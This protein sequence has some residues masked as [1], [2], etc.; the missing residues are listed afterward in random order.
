MGK[1]WRTAWTAMACAALVAAPAATASEGAERMI[2]EVN[3]LRAWHGLPPLAFSKSL[4]RSSERY[5]AWQLKADWFGHAERIRTG[6]SWAALG[7][8]LA[9]HSGHRPRVSATLRRWARSP[10][11][12][13]LLLSPLFSEAGA[14]VS[15]GRFGRG[16]ATVWV[17]QLGSR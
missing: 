15:K 14:G 13:A 5:A 16:R 10:A 2:G 6:G 9:I 17:L 12:A 11:H 1:G 4:A 3:E 7:E 8:A